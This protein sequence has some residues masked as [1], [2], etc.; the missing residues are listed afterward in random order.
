MADVPLNEIANEFLAAACGGTR[1]VDVSAA[2]ALLAVDPDLAGR[3]IHT[4]AVVGDVAAV[5]AALRRDPSRAVARGGPFTWNPLLY[6]CFSRLGLDDGQRAARY[7]R[8]AR[9]LL[10][11]GADANSQFVWQG[12]DPANGLSALFGAAGVS[13]NPE[14]T[15][16]LLEGGANPNDG[17][18]MR[19]AAELEHHA[20]LEA[21]LEHGG[22]LDDT[23]T[24]GSV[25]P[26]H[27]LLDWNY[28]RTAVEWILERGASPDV[29]VGRFGESA[30]HVAVRRRRLDATELLLDH[31]ADLDARTVGGKSAYSHARCRGFD[32]VAQLL[33]ARGAD[34]SLTAADELAV[35]LVGN[36]LERARTLIDA[37][38]GLVPD[39]G[40]EDSRILPD[41]AG[42]PMAG[43]VEL[44]LDAGADISAR[45]LDGGTALHQAA[46]FGQPEVAH[47]LISRGAPLDLRGDDHDS[48]PLGWAAHGSRHSGGA[49]G[50]A[51]LYAEIAEMLL[52][53]GASMA[54]PA[55]PSRDP[56]G[57]WLFRK[58][59]PAVAEVLR[60]F[61]GR[62]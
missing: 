12:Q 48:T 4:A 23:S 52:L 22:D 15:R 46:W 50:R 36:D 14:L 39:L 40:P 19:C 26:L 51:E 5:E 18:S 11:H 9:L 17:K 35:A 6:L 13:D 24:P 53:A 42:R 37:D 32:D 21:M 1:T 28:T 61:G 45:G 20:C 57:R 25:P 41:L 34:A 3:C 10:E 55:D 59:S 56:H 44:L 30:L 33:A 31:G 38:P 54:R 7:A 47:R 58:A 29:R 60:R 43:A 16:V 2:K 8:I 62:P 49:D 27:W